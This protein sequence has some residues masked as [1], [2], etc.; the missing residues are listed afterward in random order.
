MKN[1]ILLLLILTLLFYLMAFYY[2][3]GIKEEI[4]K[5][6]GETKIDIEKTISLDNIDVVNF[7]LNDEKVIKNKVE[8]DELKLRLVGTL[9][10]RREKGIYVRFPEDKKLKITIS[11]PEFIIP[12]KSSFKLYIDIPEDYKGEI[13]Y[14]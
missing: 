2:R 13:N 5:Y 8:S 10:G 3:G 14:N 9:N 12:I 7:Y 11:S 6:F 1:K 4:F